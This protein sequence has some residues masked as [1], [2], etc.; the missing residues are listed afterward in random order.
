M[1]AEIESSE[2]DIDAIRKL[3]SSEEYAAARRDRNDQDAFQLARLSPS[4]DFLD[5]SS[6][7][8]FSPSPQSIRIK[9]LYNQAGGYTYGKPFPE[10]ALQY[11]DPVGK[12]TGVIVQALASPKDGLISLA[13]E[14]GNTLGGDGSLL[15]NDPMPEK[16][17]AGDMVSSEASI[18]QVNNVAEIAARRGKYFV[19]ANLS[20]PC[21][22]P[23]ATQETLFNILQL[24]PGLMTAPLNGYVGAYGVFTL[25]VTTVTADGSQVATASNQVTFLQT[26]F[27]RLVPGAG[28]ASG[29]PNSLGTTW[30]F[31]SGAPLSLTT[32]LDASHS[33]VSLVVEANVRVAGLRGGFNSPG[34]GF[35]SASFQNIGK[36][37][38][39]SPVNQYFSSPFT[40]N[41][42]EAKFVEGL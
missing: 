9:Y 40:L 29:P 41:N 4:F 36:N 25:N 3:L 30:L 10:Y 21:R 42:I 18:F 16:S 26:G 34:G 27:D 28:W 13:F 23:N 32:R 6:A 15:R 14:G 17:I 33:D 8:K 2:S 1:P 24:V 20:N 39:V 22:G 7:G 38:G 5:Q 31:T 12:T 35:V 19:T 11:T 37:S